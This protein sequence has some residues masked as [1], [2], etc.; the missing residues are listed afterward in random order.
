ME[1]RGERGPGRFDKRVSEDFLK[2]CA[3]KDS[4]MRFA[5]VTG[6]SNGMLCERKI[7]T[8]GDVVMR[9]TGT[10][11]RGTGVTVDRHQIRGLEPDEE[12]LQ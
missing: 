9:R 4:N 10:D 12:L 6:Y 11:K 2:I 3:R 8:S 1:G 5:G 7:T